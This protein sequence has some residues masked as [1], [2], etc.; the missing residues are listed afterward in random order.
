[1]ENN[2]S[3]AMT[4]KE[5]GYNLTVNNA[6]WSSARVSNAPQIS[7]NG[8]TTVPITFSINAL[9]TVR[10]ITEIVTRGTNVNYALNGNFNLGA[11]LPGLADLNTPFDFS[12]STRLLR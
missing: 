11:A 8:R 1:V 5:L 10:S 4:I 2:N 3:F 7:A 9:S 6:N 12:G